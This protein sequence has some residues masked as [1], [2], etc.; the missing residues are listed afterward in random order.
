MLDARAKLVAMNRKTKVT[1]ADGTEMPAVELGFQTS[2]EHWNEYILDDGS[3][4]KIKLVAT[5]VVR[6]E[7][8]YDVNGAPV[9][10]VQ[11]TNVMAVSPPDELRKKD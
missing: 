11:S 3:V 4:V 1:L 6:L 8:Q 2:G 5:S 7:D 9:Y 10:L